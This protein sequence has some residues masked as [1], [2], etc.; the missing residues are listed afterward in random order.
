MFFW[1]S[2]FTIKFVAVFCL[3][4]AFQEIQLRKRADGAFLLVREAIE[5]KAR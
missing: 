4:D 1:V 2:E 5:S 3:S